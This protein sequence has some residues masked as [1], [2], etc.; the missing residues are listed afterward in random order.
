MPATLGTHFDL[1]EDRQPATDRAHAEGRRDAMSGEPLRNPYDPSV[2]QHRR[3]AEGWHEGETA[4]ID[5]QRKRDADI[6]DGAGES[7]EEREA[8]DEIEKH[9]I[10]GAIAAA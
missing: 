5:A 10:G 1:F 4:R 3:Y 7:A 9:G 2:E 6:F 8:L